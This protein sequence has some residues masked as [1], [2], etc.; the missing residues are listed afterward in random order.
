MAGPVSGR[1]CTCLVCHTF[2]QVQCTCWRCCIHNYTS[3]VADVLVRQ[4][5]NLSVKDSK[6][7]VA[8]AGATH[9][10]GR[11]RGH[12]S[13]GGS[14][15][16]PSQAP[17]PAPPSGDAVPQDQDGEVPGEVMTGDHWDGCHHV[18]LQGRSQLL[19]M[20]VC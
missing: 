1:C 20:L 11:G 6:V 14:M 8:S 16:G 9:T 18:T 17:A 19:Q 10:V 13:A 2:C 5:S 12:A 15:V 4:V 7:G 3:S